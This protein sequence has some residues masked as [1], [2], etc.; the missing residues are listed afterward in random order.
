MKEGMIKVSVLYTNSEG[1]KFEMDYYCDKHTPLLTG[2]LGDPLKGVSIES[3][4]SGAT[5]DSPATF[6]AIMN[7]YFDPLES[8]G[9]IFNPNADKLMKDIPNFTDIDPVV[10]ISEV[11]V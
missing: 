2:L 3:G 11:V 1:K 6:V 9:Q 10:Q 4:L 7:M 8:F 5:P